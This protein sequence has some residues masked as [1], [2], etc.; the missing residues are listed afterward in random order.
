MNKFI[1]TIAFTIGIA[2]LSSAQ[3][4][5]NTMMAGGSAS[6]SQSATKEGHKSSS[7]FEMDLKFGYFI[8]DNLAL[9]TSFGFN[10]YGTHYNSW[11]ISPFVRYYVKNIYLQAGYGYYKTNLDPGNSNI[12]YTSSAFRSELGYALFLNDNV[13]IEPAF[14][15]NQG[16]YEGKT[17]SR[18]Y[19]FKVGFQIYFNR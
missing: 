11:N 14:F 9:G 3:I 17:G 7:R 19:G 8:M 15:F 16:F 2:F 12:E 10:R 4:Y 18:D 13:A 6:L 1:F 5:K